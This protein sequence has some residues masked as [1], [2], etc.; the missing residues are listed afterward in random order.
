[1]ERIYF[2]HSATTRVDPRVVDAM[3]PYFTEEYGNASSNHTH[4]QTAKEAL[5]S[6]RQIVADSLNTSSKAI[7]FTGSGTESDNTAIKGVAEK[8][9][10]KGKHIVTSVFEHPAIAN[11]VKYLSHNGFEV[12]QVPITSEGVVDLEKLKELV[13]DDTILVT[14]MTANNEIGTVQPLKDIGEIAHDKGALFHTDAVQ[15]YGKIPIDVDKMN[16]DLLSLSAHKFHGPKGVGALFVKEGVTISPLLHG[17]GHEYGLRSST[18]NVPG[19]VGLG[20]A[21]EIAHADMDEETERLTSL[22]NKIIDE[23]TANVKESYLNGSREH[24]LPNNANIGFRWIEGE[25]ILLL[26]NHVGIS[27]S[28]GSACSSKSLRP[29]ETLLALGLKPEEV[30]GSVRITLGRFNTAEEVDY[31]IEKLPPIIE[32][33]RMMSPL[34]Q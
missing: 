15:A 32:K 9:G 19:A 23:V 3:L 5:E 24:R 29:S 18:E 27:I 10:K 14:I 26:L 13:R 25:S 21:A 31:F 12:D 8:H 17:G 4:G 22:R 1:M 20:K 7:I 33:L 6:A 11:T 30:H 28:T 34:A 16:V 2:D